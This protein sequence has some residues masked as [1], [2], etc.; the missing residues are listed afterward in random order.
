MASSFRTR[1]SSGGPTFST[2]CMVPPSALRRELP[3]MP[4]RR[5]SRW[6]ESLYSPTPIGPGPPARDAHNAGYYVSYVQFGRL[7]VLVYIRQPLQHRGGA[8]REGPEPSRLEAPT[9]DRS[10]CAEHGESCHSALGG[11]RAPPGILIVAPP[12]IP[13]NAEWAQRRPRCR[14]M[15]KSTTRPTMQA[16]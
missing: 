15:G 12:E 7:V 14:R 2:G 1:L 8:K 9:H 10:R 5:S 6:R 11:V 13:R 3:R 4:K 16:L